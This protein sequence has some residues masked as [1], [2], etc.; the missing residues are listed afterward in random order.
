MAISEYWLYPT[1]WFEKSC[2]TALEMLMSEVLCIYYPV[3]D[4]PVCYNSADR[5]KYA[6][7]YGE[8]PEKGM[9]Y[10]EGCEEL[11]RDAE[12]VKHLETQLPFGHSQHRDMYNIAKYDRHFLRMKRLGSIVPKTDRENAYLNAYYAELDRKV[13]AG[14]KNLKK[15]SAKDV[16]RRLTKK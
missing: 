11:A 16:K 2:I 9:W 4:L 15:P 13:D 10:E 6:E 3:A 14:L 7:Q 12:W 8:N 1:G 5:R